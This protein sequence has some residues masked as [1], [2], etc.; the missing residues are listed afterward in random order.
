M[1]QAQLLALSA[2]Q[3]HE[4][5]ARNEHSDRKRK[6]RKDLLPSIPNLSKRQAST[7]QTTADLA[8]GSAYL[9]EDVAAATTPATMDNDDD[10]GCQPSQRGSAEVTTS[11]SKTLRGPSGRRRTRSTRCAASGAS[12]RRA[13]RSGCRSG[14]AAPA[15]ST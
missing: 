7:I 11:T 15:P 14:T 4:V 5:T 13:R 12:S 1:S 8:P 6:T 9:R 3:A 10:P 2:H